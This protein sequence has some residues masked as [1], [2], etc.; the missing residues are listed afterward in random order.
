[1][2][3]AVSIDGA[4]VDAGLA[5]IPV[6]DRG[7][8]YG[9]GA[10]EVLRT[11]GGQPF[12]LWAHLARLTSSCERLGIPAVD[13]RTI[14]EDIG[15]AL[16]AAGNEESYVRVMVTRGVTAMGIGVDAGVPARR[17]V[18]ALPLP[19]QPEALYSRGVEVATVATARS[20]DGAG[21]AGAKASNYLPNILALEAARAR[22]GDEAI[23]VASGGE[24]LEGATSNVFVVQGEVVC[25]PPLRIGILGGITRRVVMQAAEEAGVAVRE[26]MLFPSDLYRADEAFITSTLREMVP[27]I[28]AD[29]VRIG[30]GAPGPVTGRLRAAF[31]RVRRALLAEE[32]LA[33][34]RLADERLTAER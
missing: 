6:M 32:R 12:E 33:E 26:A 13:E 20:L 24:L 2:A 1:M 29:G 9:D 25:T 23:L 16:G 17:V 18:V 7:F 21:A 27:V 30:R 3:A 34:E 31:D 22:G 11:Y 14:A 15:A 4:L 10:F 5:A 28:G 8:L 19:L